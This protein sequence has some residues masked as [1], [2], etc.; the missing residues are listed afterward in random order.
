MSPLNRSEYAKQYQKLMVI[1]ALS[2]WASCDLVAFKQ[3]ISV[4]CLRFMLNQFVFRLETVSR[5]IIFT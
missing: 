5:M 4:H 2:F 3:L 1:Y